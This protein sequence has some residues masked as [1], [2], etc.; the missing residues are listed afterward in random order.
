MI[1]ARRA[2][3]KKTK[4]LYVVSTEGAETEPIYFQEFRPARDSTFRLKILASTTHKPHPLEV[5]QR[6][7]DYE[8]RERPG[9]NTEYWAV[10]DR[11]EWSLADLSMAYELTHN[12][13]DFHIAMSY[14]CFELW[15]WLH[16][17]PN[18]PFNDRRDCQT[19]LAREW[20]Q[21]AKNRYPA[22]E[23]ISKAPMACARAEEITERASGILSSQGTQVFEL[24][25]KLS[26]EGT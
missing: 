7:F 6:L 15:L 12:R 24:V 19:R 17:R 8:R 14:P 4:R 21:F 2:G 9:A 20:V 5:V 22:A 25:R 26:S 23:L 13:A 11:D 16:I 1:H 10:V 3:F 18:R